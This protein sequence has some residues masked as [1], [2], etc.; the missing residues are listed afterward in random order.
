MMLGL[1]VQVLG[2]GRLVNE[3]GRIKLQPP[4]NGHNYYVT[5]QTKNEIIKQ[6]KFR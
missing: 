3:N 4:S 1:G 5:T 2:I 6:I